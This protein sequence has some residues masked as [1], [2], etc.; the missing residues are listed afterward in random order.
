VTLDGAAP[1]LRART[2]SVTRSTVS[3]VD[4]PTIGPHESLRP[5]APTRTSAWRRWP[6]RRARPGR[7]TRPTAR[8]CRRDNLDLDETARIFGVV[9]QRVY[10]G[11]ALRYRPVPAAHVAQLERARA[12]AHRHQRRALR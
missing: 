9:K 12:H 11:D 8:A 10:F 7:P 4:E 5:P 6:S 3:F 2:P 1:P